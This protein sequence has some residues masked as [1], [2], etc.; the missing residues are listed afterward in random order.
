[1]EI[2][3]IVSIISKNKEL[4]KESDEKMPIFYEIAEKL[5]NLLKS[6]KIFFEEDVINNGDIYYNYA[7]CFIKGIGTQKNNKK[8]HEILL[9]AIKDK[10]VIDKKNIFRSLIKSSQGVE[11]VKTEF[12]FKQY[13]DLLQ[14]TNNK[15]PQHYYF[16]AKI[17]FKGKNVKKDIDQAIKYC[18]EGK[19]NR[20][21]LL[22]MISN[23]YKKK[24]DQLFNKLSKKI[25]KVKRTEIKCK[26][27]DEES[28]LCVYC[29]EKPKEVVFVPCGHKCCCKE[30]GKN[31]YEKNQSCPI[32]KG[33][34]KFVLEKIYE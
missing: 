17:Y 33:E 32:C 19:K 22:L 3:L 30:D 34:I 7:R 10:R 18:Q 5:Y 14:S 11:E 9:E 15:Y 20:S 8:A 27:I 1:M 23:Y 25:D 31:L 21:D 12:Y 6:N 24:C 4:E 2:V 26:Q 29:L 16:L 13:L 28:N